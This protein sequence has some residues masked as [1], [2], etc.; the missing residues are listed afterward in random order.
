[1]GSNSPATVPPVGSAMDRNLRLIPVHQVFASSLA[2]IPVM[3]LFTRARFDLDGAVLLS[4]V[5]YL[6]VVVLEVPSGW[7]SDQLGRVPT[8]RVA[9]ASW[10]G[11]HA[12]FL[13]GNDQLVVIALGQMLLAAGFASLSGTN[14]SFHYDSLESMGRAEEYAR[15]QARISAYGYTAIAVS[16]VLGGALGLIDLRLAFGASLVFALL[17]FG[18]T[19][20]LVEPPL[21]EGDELLA[22]SGL[23]SQLSLCVGYLNQRYL[24]WIFFYGIVLVTLEHVAA[25]VLQPWLTE[26][27][28]RTAADLGSTPLY[29]G[30]VYAGVSLLGAGAARLS[31]PVA[32][33]FGVAPTLLA[34][35]GLSAVIVTGMAVSLSVL[36]LVLVMFRSV[37]GAAAPVLI[38]AAVAPRVA[39]RHRA[40]FL[41]LNSLGG[42]LQ[43]GVLLVVT[44]QLIN[45]DLGR[46]LWIFTA[47][48]WG[49]VMVLL[50]SAAL[51]R[52]QEEEGLPAEAVAKQRRSGG[53]APPD[54]GPY[55][56]AGSDDADQATT[57]GSDGAS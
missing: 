47:V 26:L 45:D 7:M 44:S 52:G 23:G 39:R 13:L 27:A 2:W 19:F 33:R 5:Y 36:A 46:T 25:E 35:A 28:N 31:A 3:V 40:T 49:L 20:L 56:V 14:V 10:V 24:R 48:S 29:S 38:S 15:R 9:A 4:A 21:S 37:Q 18:V 43:Y 57:R 53:G 30:L 32:E 34:L 51:V 1:M 16:A 50:F 22:R 54:R 8:L 6:S 41:S 11:A 17:Q 42:R 55:S 12:C